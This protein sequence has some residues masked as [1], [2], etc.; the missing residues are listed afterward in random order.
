M[1]L[2]GIFLPNLLHTGFNPGFLDSFFPPHF[3]E[4]QYNDYGNGWGDKGNWKNEGWNK[5]WN[6]RRNGR[7]ENALGAIGVGVLKLVEKFKSG[8]STVE[9]CVVQRVCEEK[10]SGQGGRISSLMGG[11]GENEIAKDVGVYKVVRKVLDG[12]TAICAK[13]EGLEVCKEFSGVEESFME[14][15]NGFREK[16]AEGAEKK[17]GE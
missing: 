1:A 6:G 2:A 15:V 11:L 3:T 9:K 17:K 7:A 8:V 16:A 14:L 4:G 10:K 12:D 13:V 5:D